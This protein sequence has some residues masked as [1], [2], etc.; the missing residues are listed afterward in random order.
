MKKA[1]LFRFTMI[2]IPLKHL[3]MIHDGLGGDIDTFMQMM[4]DKDFVS[5]LESAKEIF[6]LFAME[7]RRSVNQLYSATEKLRE[8][9]EEILNEDNFKHTGKRISSLNNAKIAKQYAIDGW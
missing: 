3:E 1:N 7:V 4:D 9:R 8:T 6:A 2:D 5:D